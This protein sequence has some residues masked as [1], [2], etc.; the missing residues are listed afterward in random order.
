ME[1]P[2]LQPLARLR[3]PKSAASRENVAAGVELVQ[4]DDAL[5]EHERELALQPLAQLRF[6]VAAAVGLDGARVDVDISFA[7]L[8]AEGGHVVGEGVEGAATREVEFGVVPVAGE[9]AV[10][11]G[12]AAQGEAHV[13]AAV[14]EG[15]EAALVVDDEDGPS[16]G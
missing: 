16:L 6:P 13:G 8:D 1:R 7:G 2:V 10:A 9:D 3:M 12:A 14:V 4:A 5:G 11:D 15:V